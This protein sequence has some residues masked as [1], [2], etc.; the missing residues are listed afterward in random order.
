MVY[1]QLKIVKFDKFAPLLVRCV[2][3]ILIIF[4]IMI[5]F[6]FLLSTMTTTSFVINVKQIKDREVVVEQLEERSI[7]TP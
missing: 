5:S 7:L 4:I 1:G 3:S 6:L 2:A